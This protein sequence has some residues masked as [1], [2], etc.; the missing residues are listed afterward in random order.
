MAQ[1]I[2]EMFLT[3]MC[4]VD[5][6]NEYLENTEPKLYLEFID[7]LVNAT[8]QV[9]LMEWPQEQTNGYHDIDIGG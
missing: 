7:G 4:K 1:K 6:F 8:E 3:A 2:V 5:V 9:I